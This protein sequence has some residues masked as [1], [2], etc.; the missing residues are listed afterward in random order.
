MSIL[1]ADIGRQ[2][3]QGLEVSVRSSALVSMFGLMDTL[4]NII[5]Y[6]NILA[7]I[8]RIFEL[9]DNLRVVEYRFLNYI[10]TTFVMN[11]KL[12]IFKPE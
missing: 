4:L 10:P 11:I 2:V 8:C 6:A 12:G 3:E 1:G 5:D 7:A 9:W